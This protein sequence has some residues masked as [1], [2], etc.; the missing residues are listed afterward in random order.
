MRNFLIKLIVRARNEDYKIDDAINSID[1]ILI[2]CQK[3]F[4]LIRGEFKKIGIKGTKKKVFIGKK[5]VLKHKSHIYF[6][7]KVQIKDYVEIN[8]LSKENVVLGENVTIGKYSIIRGTG[9][10]QSLGKGIKIGKNF[11]CGDF[12]FFGCSGGIIIGENV[13]LGQNVRFHSQN[14]KFDRLDIP[15]REQG[16]VS[17]GIKVGNDCWIGAG[18]TILDGVTIGN[19]CVIGGNTLVNI[20]IP[21]YA[22]AVGNPVKIIKF[23]NEKNN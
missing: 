23:R 1:I 7:N 22:V 20:D 4:D 6:S 11:G 12:C 5:V 15:M 21:D 16:V 3:V 2:I 13:M 17:K 18:A 10:I 14:H 9:A 8:G 19:G